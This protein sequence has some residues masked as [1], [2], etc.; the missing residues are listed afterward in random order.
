MLDGMSDF[1]KRFPMKDFITYGWIPSFLFL[2]LFFGLLWLGAKRKV[3]INW[4]WATLGVF[5]AYLLTHTA[6]GGI[7]HQDR[8]LASYSWYDE[9]SC[10]M[11]VREPDAKYDWRCLPVDGCTML[12]H[13]GESW[14]Y[15]EFEAGK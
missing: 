15:C 12:F 3:G 9:D 8:H 5:T 2:L 1:R 7:Y 11:L 4:V 10:P 14:H 13:N 6:I